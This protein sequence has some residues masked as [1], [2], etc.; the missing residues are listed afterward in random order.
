VNDVRK[1]MNKLLKDLSN[2][3]NKEQ[4]YRIRGE[5]RALKN[6]LQN[7]EDKTL[8]EIIKRSYVILST[9]VGAADSRF[10]K[11]RLYTPFI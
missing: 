9:N 7:R 10:L 3:R 1:E 11:V 8:S 5:L 6:E 4:R 2:A